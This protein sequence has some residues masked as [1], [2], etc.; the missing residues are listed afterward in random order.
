[1]VRTAAVARRPPVQP[2]PPVAF[3]RPLR[4]QLKT[5]RGQSGSKKT[6]V[7]EIEPVD[8]VLLNP[9]SEAQARAQL[10]AAESAEALARAELE[11]AAADLEFSDAEVERARELS[12][13]GTL[14]ERDL[15]A[16]EQAHKSA[17]ASY[18]MARAAVQVRRYE[19]ERARAELM[20]PAEA[21]ARRDQCGCVRAGERTVAEHLVQ[22]FPWDVAH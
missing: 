16:A 21:S 5:L 12:A 9:R 8:P 19:L 15:E 20:T 3:A 22:R 13:N 6:V 1:M 10:S 14:S 18:A 7:A 4:G 17:H 2:D 11:K